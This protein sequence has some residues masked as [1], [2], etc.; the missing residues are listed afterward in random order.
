MSTWAERGNEVCT[1]PNARLRIESRAFLRLNLRV[2]PEGIGRVARGVPKAACGDPLGQPHVEVEGA[3]CRRLGQNA[4]GRHPLRPQARGATEEQLRAR[5]DV[6]GE[7]LGADEDLVH[8]VTQYLRRG[9]QRGHGGK[10]A[11]VGQPTTR[12]EAVG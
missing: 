7:A 3:L 2:Y 11:V 6:E 8:A 1:R 10:G 12:A 9:G 5:A 4:G